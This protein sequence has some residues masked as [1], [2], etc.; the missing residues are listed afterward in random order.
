MSAKILSGIDIREQYIPKLK[1]DFST[2]TA[3]PILT[4]I[5]VGNR[6]DTAS[7]IKAKKIFGEKVGI[8]VR[9]ISFKETVSNSDII[10]TIKKENEDTKVGGIIV[11]LPL[12][13]HLDRFAIIESINPKKDVDALTSINI[14][15]WMEND[16]A[17]LLPATARGVKTMLDFYKINLSGKKVAVL[18]RSVLVGKP[19]AL[20]CQNKNATVTVCHSKTE[21]LKKEILLADIVI[22]ATGKINLI[23]KDNVRAGQIII[24]VGINTINDQKLELEGKRKIVGDANFLEVGDIVQAIS[25]VPGGVGPLTVLSLFQN[26]YDLYRLNNN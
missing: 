17:S 8:E 16:P 25:P 3:K 1:A 13:S 14:K 20:M 15:K 7:Y 4:I 26:L 5:E 21:D 24:D 18:G 12:P 2:L 19:I 23:N 11:Q 6:P 10:S 9:V 22:S